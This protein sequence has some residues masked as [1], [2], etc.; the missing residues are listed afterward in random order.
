[1][2][3]LTLRR[4]AFYVILHLQ[5]IMN[6]KQVWLPVPGLEKVL[7]PYQLWWQAHW[8]GC[9]SEGGVDEQVQ[10]AAWMRSHGTV[11]TQDTWLTLILLSQ[12][13]QESCITKCLSCF[14]SGDVPRYLLL[15]H[16]CTFLRQI[17]FIKD[18]ALF[19][20]PH[21]LIPLGN[22]RPVLDNKSTPL[23]LSLTPSNPPIFSHPC[24]P[25]EGVFYGKPGPPGLTG[26][27][28]W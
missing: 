9:T 14:C 8:R 21:M 24:R 6:H 28:N 3:Q 4:R 7:L 2:C 1:M 17:V 18:T 25:E 23:S 15:V 27:V 11:D 10:H 13:C 12:V 26:V 16:L 19:K 5:W 22:W 20:T